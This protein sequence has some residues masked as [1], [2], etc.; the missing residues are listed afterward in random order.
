MKTLCLCVMA[1]LLVLTSP[2]HA[3]EVNK[4]THL[5][6]AQQVKVNNVLAKSYGLQSGQGTTTSSAD[7]QPG[8]CGTTRIG[9]AQPKSRASRIENTVVA[10]GDVIIVN[11][12]VSTFR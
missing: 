5:A 4:R 11:R 8:E 9:T 1:S 6:P 10:R 2:L 7:A 12:N 3:A